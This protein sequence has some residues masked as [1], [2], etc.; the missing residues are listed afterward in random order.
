[1]DRREFV[2]M[3]G[4]L[5]V[6]A[7]PAAKGKSAAVGSNASGRYTVAVYYFP[8]WHGKSRWKSLEN[9][10]SIYKGQYEPEVPLWGQLKGNNPTTMDKYI[11][12]MTAHGINTIIFDWYRFQTGRTL[13]DSLRDG[14]LKA[15][16]R[17][18]I[19]FSL[20]WANPPVPPYQAVFTRKRFDQ[21]ADEAIAYFKHS[22]YWTINGK[23]YFSIYWLGTLLEHLGGVAGAR[24]A[25]EGFRRR[26]MRAGLPGVHLNLVTWKDAGGEMWFAKGQHAPNV[27]GKKI[28][29]PAQLITALGFDSTTWYT[30]THWVAPRKP[31]QNYISWGDAA[32]AYWENQPALGVPFFPNVTMGW[33]GMPQHEKGIIVN[34]TPQNFGR[35]LLRAKRW[36]DT[37]PASMNILT[38]NAWNEWGEGSYLEPDVVHRMAYL[39]EV[40]K[41]FPPHG[42][43]RPVPGE[44]PAP[45]SIRK[46]RF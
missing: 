40:R 14:F 1:M 31:T 16:D 15:S 9:V 32:V 29:T 26:A 33:D 28:Q 17:H 42:R 20:M 19:K 45:P 30:W 37:H 34:N 24:A 36:L 38:I 6:G 23:P 5:A 27:P 21:V 8:G 12:A 11:H 10:R 18:R 25:L 3:T 22:N 4:A 35:F 44:Y 39:D 41:V 7:L 43:I 46:S 13:E 2:K